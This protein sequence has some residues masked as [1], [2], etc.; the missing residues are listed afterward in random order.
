MVVVSLKY[1]LLV[2]RANNRG[3]GGIMALLALATTSIG[4]RPRMG[5]ALLAIGVFGASLF[6]GDAVL[7]PAISV[8]SAVEG[9]EVGTSAFKPY[10]VPLSTGIL[11]GLFLIQKHGTSVIGM[12]FGPV[13]AVWFLALGAAGVWNIQK[14]P[15]ILGALNPLHAMRFVTAH[16]YASFV[17]L[18]SVLLAI[19]GA[20][21][22]YADMG[23]FGKRAVRIAWFG[24]SRAR[25]GAELFRPG[26]A[27]ARRPES[28]RE[29]VLSRL[30][31]VGALSDGGAGH[32][33]HRDRLASDDLRGV[34]DD[35]AGDPAGLPAAHG[36]PAYVLENDG[37]D[38]RAG[39][40]L[41][42]ACRGDSR[43]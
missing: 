41:D 24:A 10:V 8:L 26:R 15:E 19:T 36:G 30:S 34:L 18:G 9:L 29:P 2:L 37:P 27:P 6:Y 12:L 4:D 14:N 11:V 23:H 22:L 3:E 40:E 31:P 7:T 35:A 33:G 38:L 32:R 25:A 5:A 16:G 20:E 17:V 39:G 13:C 43:R 21:A 28:A 42:P 1:V